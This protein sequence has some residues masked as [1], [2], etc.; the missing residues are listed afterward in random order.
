[1]TTHFDLDA[2]I[3]RIGY[4]GERAPNLTTLRSVHWLH[5]TTFPFE[6][7]ST[8]MRWPVPLDTQSLQ[9]KM[10]QEGRGGYCFEQNLLLQTALMALGFNV[11]G[12]SARVLSDQTSSHLR[13]RTHMMLHV[14]LDGDEFIADGGFGGMTLTEP[15][16]LQP[17]IVQMTSHERR[18]LTREDGEWIM[19]AQTTGGWR[20]LY[21]FSLLPHLL[22]DYEV[23]NWYI[24][25][26]PNS[27]FTK[28]LT[29]ARPTPNGRY[30]LR[31]NDFAEH[32]L[33]G[34]TVRTRLTTATALRTALEH[35]F[36]IRL[37]DS[38]ELAATLQRL[39]EDTVTAKSG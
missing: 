38:P 5:A 15:I 13:P 29:V 4:T 7:I 24:C 39:A 26:H 20:T 36:L 37:P 2:Y 17:E 11:T 28:G 1:M 30:T 10:V 31:N 25:T 18:K 12:L 22:P 23:A 14:D 9:K 27:Q 21:R 35:I 32:D 6:N 19:Q 8:L 34:R 16:R 3:E 33:N